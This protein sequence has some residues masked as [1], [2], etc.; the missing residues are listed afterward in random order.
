M[1]ALPHSPYRK[2]NGE[3]VFSYEL[4]APRLK[5]LVPSLFQFCKGKISGNKKPM[6]N[7]LR[8]N[9]ACAYK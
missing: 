5:Q 1:F 4:N 3:P 7:N 9:Y 2:I 8:L 6:N